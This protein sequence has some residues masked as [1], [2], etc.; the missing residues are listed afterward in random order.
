MNEIDKSNSNVPVTQKLESMLKELLSLEIVTS[1]KVDN[2]E[3]RLTNVEKR[4][5]QHE[6]ETQL[7][8]QQRNTIRRTV[9]RQVYML[10]GLPADKRQWTTSDRMVASK[11]SNIFHRRCYSEVSRRGHL[12]SPYGDTTQGNFVSASKDIEAWTPSN[13]IKG[14]KKEAD[15]NRL[16]QM[17]NLKDDALKVLAEMKVES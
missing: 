4:Q 5:D 8:T 14:L 7:T 13:G 3:N 2:I 12:A 9:T 10:L 15:D 11:Y 17:K 16:A 6:R 1:K